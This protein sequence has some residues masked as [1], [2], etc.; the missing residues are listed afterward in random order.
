[1]WHFTSPAMLEPTL[2]DRMTFHDFQTNPGTVGI[3]CTPC[4]NTLHCWWCVCEGM[5]CRAIPL[6]LEKQQMAKLPKQRLNHLGGLI[7]ASELVF[8]LKQL[9]PGAGLSGYI[10]THSKDGFGAKACSSVQ[11]AG[12]LWLYRAQFKL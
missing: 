2:R 12:L 4:G 10:P 1:M 9:L 7:S 11:A 6:T 5:V 3:N 8:E